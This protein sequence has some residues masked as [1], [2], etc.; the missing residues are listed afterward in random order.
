MHVSTG[1]TSGRRLPKAER[2]MQAKE[3]KEKE[4]KIKVEQELKEMHAEIEL[5]DVALAVEADLQDRARESYMQGYRGAMAQ[6]L[7][8]GIQYTG[9]LREVMAE[10][11]FQFW[12]DSSR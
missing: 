2:E 1:R 8:R 11:S 7:E 12:W 3:K 6:R 5:K 10:R 4:M 9:V